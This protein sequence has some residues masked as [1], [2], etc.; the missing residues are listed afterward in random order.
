[1]VPYKIGEITSMGWK[2]LNI[3]YEYKNKFY[4]KYEYETLIKKE[5]QTSIKKQQTI[6]SFTKKVKTFIYYF[7]AAII[8]SF[9]KTLL[10]I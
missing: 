3:E 2:V 9:L 6:E 7:V 8:V 4:S 5:K 10:G 1:M